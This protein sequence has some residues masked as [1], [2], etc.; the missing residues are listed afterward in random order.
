[1]ANIP[2]DY[3]E[4]INDGAA[5]AA[6]VTDSGAE[7]LN[8]GGVITTD[9][10]YTIHTFTSNTTF[11]PGA[12][13]NVEVLVIAGGGGGG[14]GR[15]G[16]AGGG[17]Y[18]YSASYAV[19]N[20]SGV[21]VGI[22]AGG[23]STINGSDSTFG[24]LTGTG[25]GGGGGEPGYSA[26]GTG[27]NGGCGG[28]PAVTY[29]AGTGSQGGNGGACGTTTNYYGGGG[30]GG[31][32]NGG[33]GAASYGGVG[34]AGYSSTIRTG[35]T[36]YYGGGG[37]GAGNSTS[38]GAGGSGGGGAGSNPGV[39]GVA[40]TA[41][42]GGGGGGGGG[43][44]TRG[45]GGAGGSGIVIIR[46]LTSAFTSVG[47]DLLAYSEST[48]KTQGTYSL[49]GIAAI[50]A[51]LNNTLT[52]TFT[53]TINL[54]DQNIIK[55]D[56]RSSRTGSNI[57]IGIH[58]SGGTTSEIT[59]NIISANIWQTVVLDISAVSNVNKDAINS[60]IVTIVNADAANTFYI[61]NLFC[62]PINDVFGIIS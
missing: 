48:I 20:S 40:G 9:G 49:K 52:H 58:D 39:T 62:S 13:G 24:T 10:L 53:P 11:T 5:Q 56:I 36:V 33:A 57:K 29:S 46:C 12:T 45:L 2:I 43:G 59:P 16:G 26:H 51:S 15:G 14:Y 7:Y 19:T 8:T 50:T 30:G 27:N 37:G 54:S 23:A 38:P 47:T 42:T 18:V 34:G 1:M 55:F 25:G 41:N 6:Y 3:E 60:I 61:D 31:G 35:A 22:G 28:G 17:G 21:T 32:A 44:A 4:Y